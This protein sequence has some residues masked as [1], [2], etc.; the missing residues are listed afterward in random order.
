MPRPSA[1][2]NAEMFK[3]VL[4]V[5]HVARGKVVLAAR[6]LPQRHQFGAGA[7]RVHHLVELILAVAVPKHEHGEVA[8]HS[9]DPCLAPHLEEMRRV[10]P[11]HLKISFRHLSPIIWRR[12]L[13]HSD[14]TLFGLHQ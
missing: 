11:Y 1:K 10:P 6:V 3:L 8:P 14:L 4:G 7:H 12:W 5:H 13:V 9:L 2:P